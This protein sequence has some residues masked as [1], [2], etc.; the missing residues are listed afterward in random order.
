M[1]PLKTE[2]N[3]LY[4]IN[5]GGVGT[6]LTRARLRV[7]IPVLE[8]GNW[9]G[10]EYLLLHAVK[11]KKARTGPNPAARFKPDVHPRSKFT[12]CLEQ[13]KQLK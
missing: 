4:K 2:R 9:T 10:K 5:I 11:S 8:R 1:M 6:G 13:E 3:L 12:K 7:R